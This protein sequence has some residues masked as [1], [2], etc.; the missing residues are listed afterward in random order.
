MLMWLMFEKLPSQT[1]G[2]DIV[3]M[4]HTEKENLQHKSYCIIALQMQSGNR[5]C[6]DEKHLMVD[7]LILK[8]F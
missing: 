1:S 3:L 5:L 6:K 2:V 7:T 4:I 8:G